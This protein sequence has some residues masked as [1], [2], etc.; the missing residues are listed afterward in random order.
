MTDEAARKNL[1][2]VRFFERKE[3]DI[4]LERRCLTP[5]E[6][7]K[8]SLAN[9]KHCTALFVERK[10]VPDVTEIFEFSLAHNYQ[11]RI[12]GTKHK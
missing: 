7:L 12:G 2:L 4:L 9:H 1:L 6:F 3:D 10:G 11:N 8:L 5:L